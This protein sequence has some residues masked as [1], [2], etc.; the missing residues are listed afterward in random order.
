MN[1]TTYYFQGNLHELQHTPKCLKTAK[2]LIAKKAEWTIVKKIHPFYLIEAEKF[3]MWVWNYDVKDAQKEKQRLALA[4]AQQVQYEKEI[5]ELYIEHYK[6][7]PD[8]T[9]YGI[10]INGQ[11]IKFGETS[12]LHQIIQPVMH[13]DRNNVRHLVVKIVSNDGKKSMRRVSVIM[14]RVFMPDYRIR[15]HKV[16]FRD[17]DRKNCALYNLYHVS[18]HKKTVFL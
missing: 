3:Q 14:A 7:I 1:N 2:E 5:K 10:N 12:E 17:G 9:Q 4:K 6:Q 11:V 18:K 13:K 16:L 15:K 8:A